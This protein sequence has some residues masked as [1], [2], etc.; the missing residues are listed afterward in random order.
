M[1]C[2]FFHRNFSTLKFSDS[3]LLWLSFHITTYLP[4][5]KHLS[6]KFFNESIWVMN[7]SKFLLRNKSITTKGFKK[8]CRQICKRS[9][10]LESLTF[11]FSMEV[12]TRIYPC[13]DSKNIP[14]DFFKSLSHFATS[15]LRHLKDLRLL[16]SGSYF[17]RYLFFSNSL[18]KSLEEKG[19]IILLKGCVLIKED[20]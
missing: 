2:N 11:D 12:Q 15:Y 10:R 4:N 19:R 13:S 20:I 3:E 7:L 8:F 1:S 17:P 6:I 18:H 5:L 14:S 16:L 9:K